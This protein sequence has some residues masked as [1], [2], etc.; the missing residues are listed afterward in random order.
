MQI[1]KIGVNRQKTANQ[2]A[3]SEITMGSLPIISSPQPQSEAKGLSPA[4][5]VER[6]EERLADIADGGDAIGG[7]GEGERSSDRIDRIYL[8][9]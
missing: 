4:F 3:K 8:F 7:G 5:A 9:S 2:G 6:R 1:F